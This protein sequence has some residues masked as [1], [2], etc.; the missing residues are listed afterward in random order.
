MLKV[1][2]II[3]TYN[4]AKYVGRAIDSVLAQTYKNY[5]IIVIDDGSTD[6]TKEVLKEFIAKIEYVY[7]E[8]RGL[9]AARNT[10]IK[11]S[12]GEYLVFLDADD[13][14]PSEKLAVQVELLDKHPE[15]GWVYS[16]GY[17]VDEKGNILERASERFKKPKSPEGDIFFDLLSGNFIPVNTVMV[18]RKCMDVGFFDESLTSYED[19]DFWLRVSA[20]YKVK[21]I[22][23]PMAFI[24]DRKESMSKD[25]VKTKSNKIRVI[26]KMRR[27][28]PHLVRAHLKFVNKTLLADCYNWIGFKYY[29][30]GKFNEAISKLL[31]S[32]KRYPLQ[33]KAY[34]Y[35]LFAFL[36]SFRKKILNLKI[37]KTIS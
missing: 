19:C 25:T 35:L 12:R 9:S 1:S 21:Y 11:R 26:D 14:L 17:Y 7:Q 3:P 15:I 28:Y 23:K 6:N 30:D 29:H 24:N 31:N 22:D 33:K 5:E 10:G 16:D 13:Y 27:L 2:V 4:H 36:K 34:L 20:D 32:I 18:R 8:N 37:R